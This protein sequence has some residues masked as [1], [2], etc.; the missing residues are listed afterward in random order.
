MVTVTIRSMHFFLLKNPVGVLRSV[1][2][3]SF[4]NFTSPKKLLLSLVALKIFFSKAIE[5]TDFISIQI[6]LK[7]TINH[8]FKIKS[9][10]IN[11]DLQRQHSG[12]KKG[13]NANPR[14]ALDGF[15]CK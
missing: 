15:P 3:H 9:V 4:T 6:S 11:I 2:N 10:C 1:R 7:D 5:Y 13:D 12:T 14:P 8:E